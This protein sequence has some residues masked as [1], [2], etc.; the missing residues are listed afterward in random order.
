M[1]IHGIFPIVAILDLLARNTK[2]TKSRTGRVDDLRKCTSRAEKSRR[3]T[4]GYEQFRITVA[5]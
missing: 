5:L 1:L 4:V 2:S 3:T